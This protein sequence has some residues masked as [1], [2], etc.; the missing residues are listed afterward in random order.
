MIGYLRLVRLPNVFTAF[1]DVIAGFVII[2][3][4]GASL[5]TGDW[6]ALP[7]LLGSSAALYMAGMAFNDI[8]D[9]KEDAEIRPNRP[10]PSGQVTFTGALVCAFLLTAIGIGLAALAGSDSLLRAVLLTG[11]ILQYNFRAKGTLLF[12]PLVLGLCRFLNI[13]LGMSAHPDFAFAVETSRSAM[14]IAWAP[15]IA[16]GVYAAGLTA[17]SA[18]EEQ[19]KQTRA[20]LIGWALCGGAILWAGLTSS[21]SAWLALVPLALLLQFLTFKLR[22]EGTPQAARNLVRFG[23]MGVCV[24]DAGLILGFAGTTAWPYA[25]ACLALP[26]PGLLIAK[27]LA[28]KEA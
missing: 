23:V 6:H 20:I 10:I 2:G 3:S 8:A 11:A 12:G 16:T 5:G 17:F 21:P 9:R 4:R 15:A 7:H 13:Q 1:A 18:Q 28:Q 22:K 25:A 14:N 19:G 24:L 27:W 26:I